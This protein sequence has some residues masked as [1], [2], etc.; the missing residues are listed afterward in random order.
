MVSFSGGAVS[1]RRFEH[2]RH[3]LPR[4]LRWGLLFAI[5]LSATAL[6]F[7]FTATTNTALFA[8]YYPTLLAVN[9]ALVGLLAILVIFQ[10]VRLGRRLRR[11]DFG[12]RLALRLVLVLALMS[13]LPGALIYAV[14]VK[15]LA[16]S[17]DSWFEVRLDKALEGGL[18]LGR[19]ALDNALKELV[20]RADIIADALAPLD[21]AEQGVALSRLRERVGVQEAVLFNNRGRIVSYAGNEKAG[22]VPEALS[23]AALRQARSAQ[24]FAGIESAEE[25]GLYLRV[26]VPV[27]SASL[28]AEG[29]ALQVVQPVSGQLAAEADAVRAGYRDYQE[30]LLAR[31]GLK[32]IYGITLTLTLLVALLSAFLIAFLLSARLAAPLLTLAEG[33][34]AV[35]QG[36]FS[37]RVPVES[38]DELGVLSQSFNTMTEQL[39]EAK[40][41]AVQHEAEISAAKAY[42]ESLLANLS[43]GVMS[44]DRELHLRS[45][46]PS[47]AAILGEPMEELVGA[48]LKS[49]GARSAPLNAI[50]ETI[51]A[52]FES[53]RGAEWER[54]ISVSRDGVDKTLLF[55]GTSLAAGNESGH[56]VVFDDISHV[57]QAQRH[58]AWSEVARRLAHEIKNPLTPI[59]LSAERMQ[60]KL[61]D[62]LPPAEAEMLNRSTRT[63]VEQVAAL[64]S[65]VDAFSQYARSPEPK[66]QWLDLNQVTREVLGLYESLGRRMDLRLAPDLPLI[67]GDARLLR[68][69]FHNLMQN[70]QDAL[71]E[72]AEP[73]IVV[74]SEDTGRTIR[75]SIEDNG[76]GFPEQMK[77]RL[78]EPYVTTK[79]KGTGLGLS[80]VKKIIEDHGGSVA[81][82]NVKPHGAKVSID[83]PRRTDAGPRAVATE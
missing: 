82:E 41:T 24:R 42:L 16:R 81:I 18:N 48:E 5:G 62:R 43:A 27:E 51:E 4:P 6:Y 39:A 79:Q 46:N 37:Q 55:R 34:R 65:M 11:R 1:M 61:V 21:P 57:I 45:V 2:H 44:F 8:K 7:L 22:F 28:I 31:V 17:I 20:K 25:R 14:S 77:Q 12:S 47:A 35:A 54:Q 15:F 40:S 64:K 58:A 83:L 50:A 13:L 49:F 74:I 10:L 59:Q 70:A 53:G 71:A 68:Q 52:G 60:L 23:P 78:F 26:V 30:L 36:D 75:F 76:G 19:G 56:V 63:I 3:W 32:R 67:Q 29:R 66:L 72:V 80:I 38:K 73:R 33:T 69:V 9:G